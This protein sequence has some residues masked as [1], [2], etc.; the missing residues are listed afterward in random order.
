[1]DRCP[2]VVPQP[3]GGLTRFLFRLSFARLPL[4]RGSS[5][6]TLTIGWFGGISQRE[7]PTVQPRQPCL[8]VARVLFPPFTMDEST[9]HSALLY[10]Q[11][12]PQQSQSQSQQSAAY[13]AST[14]SAHTQAP[15]PP[16]K[17]SRSR[18]DPANQKRR[19]S[20]PSFFYF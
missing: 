5:P 19:E 4:L 8:S 3:P 16:K 12:P 20:T 9:S 15:P 2:Y 7:S 17:K 11:P 1:M 10:S 13:P 14:L 18:A 6:L